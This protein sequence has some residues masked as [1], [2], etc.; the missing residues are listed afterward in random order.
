MNQSEV[1]ISYAWGGK[2]EKIVNELESALQKQGLTIVRDKRDLGFKGLITDFM[3]RIG[4]GKAVVIVISDKYLKSPYCMFELME[5]YRNRDFTKHIFP[6]VLEDATIFEPIPKLAYLK[7]WREK[8]A[9]L[10]KAIEEF[11][12]DAI[13]VIGDDYKIYHKVFSNFGEV[14]NV[15][16]DINALTPDIHRA[17]NF[18]HLYHSLL[19]RLE[20]DSRYT[21]RKDTQKLLKQLHVGSQ[22]YYQE[23]TGINGPYH[24]LN[25]SEAMLAGI[26]KAAAVQNISPPLHPI[27]KNKEG[28]EFALEN[29]LQSLWQQ[30]K[31]H[32]ILL[33]EGG[34]G[35]TVSL[36]HF[37]EAVLKNNQQSDHQSIPLFITLHEY[38]T[39]SEGERSDF[40]AKRIAWHYLGIKENRGE[41]METLWEVFKTAP[42]KGSPNIVLLLDGFNE[43]TVEQAERRHLLLELQE[44]RQKGKAVQMVL[45]SRYEMNFTWAEGFENYG[46]TAVG[47]RK[48]GGR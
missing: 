1:F 15:L 7:Y 22:Q 32:T 4:V 36:I 5:M 39:V 41:A 44:L 31:P 37:W 46:V 13:T 8:K 28:E 16:K 27:V 35:K 12:P 21:K 19:E 30:E 43:V 9:E 2:S 47:P 40:V 3:Q 34:M 6:I 23:L 24:H 38:H 29:C 20:E 45:S 42:Q 26:T 33:G 10:E 17:S 25:I 48:S 18:Q 14:V 11:G